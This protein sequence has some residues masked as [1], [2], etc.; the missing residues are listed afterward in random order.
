[1]D[2]MVDG[3]TLNYVLSSEPT[4]VVNPKN[5]DEYSEIIVPYFS[6]WGG[7]SF[8]VRYFV[9]YKQ[10]AQ[11]SM[12]II[13][14]AILLALVVFLVVFFIITS[15]VYRIIVT[16]ITKLSEIVREISQG[17]YGKRAEIN[18]ND[19]IEIL[20]DS[21]N[22]M[23]S[24]LE[25]DIVDLRELDKLKDE[26]IDIAANNLKMPLVHLKFDL[27]YLLKNAKRELSNK[28]YQLLE[29]I[30]AF[31]GKLQLL[32]EDLLSISAI[33]K[34]KLQNSIFM[35][36]DLTDVLSESIDEIKTRAQNSKVTIKKNFQ[37]EKAP[38]LG[39]LNKLQQVFLVLLDNALK[40]SPKGGQVTVTLTEKE[41]DFLV[42]VSDA[43]VGMT[44]EELSKIFSKFYRAPSSAIYNKEGSGLGLYLVKAIIG[45]HHGSIWATSVKDKGSQFYVALLKKDGFRDQMSKE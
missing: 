9:S 35:P 42:E 39:D 44:Q 20:A 37:V 33:K 31:S 29:D 38:I 43:G 34:G 41:H 45:V 12:D 24:K 1:K 22:K 11:T 21:T 15:S 28:N 14:Q 40:Y 5:S 19:E 32:G 23:A 16:P 7:H 3:Q 36:L 2:E 4:Y 25:Q 6:D 30:D 27:K 10:V 26:F 17:N 8:S 13:K 18:T